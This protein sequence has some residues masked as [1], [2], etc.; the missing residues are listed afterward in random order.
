M[1]V[2]LSMLTSTLQRVY[3]FCSG[4]YARIYIYERE[5]ENMIT[6]RTESVEAAEIVHTSAW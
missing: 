6:N 2:G 1:D 5:K 4:E 3:S